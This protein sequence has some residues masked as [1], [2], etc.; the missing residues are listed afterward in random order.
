MLGPEK[1]VVMLFVMLCLMSSTESCVR[2]Q[3][4]TGELDDISD[5]ANSC[6]SF[7]YVMTMRRP[8]HA[9]DLDIEIPKRSF[10]QE[11]VVAIWSNVRG[12]ARICRESGQTPMMKDP[13]HANT[14][15]S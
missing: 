3:D 2:T 5:R 11:S 9:E 1:V 15:V 7:Y 14:L 10:P 12:M 6:E 8:G 13:A 4:Q